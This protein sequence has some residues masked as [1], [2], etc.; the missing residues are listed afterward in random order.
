MSYHENCNEYHNKLIDQY[1]H[2]N[3]NHEQQLL[4]VF[5][6]G[7][8]TLYIN[9]RSYHFILFTLSTV[10]KDSCVRCIIL[11]TCNAFRAISSISTDSTATFDRY[12]ISIPENISKKCFFFINKVRNNLPVLN[13]LPEPVN[14]ITRHVL[15]MFNC[16]KHVFNSLKKK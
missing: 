1:Q 12:L 9:E 5:H 4:L 6:T 8:Q 14:T 13:A 10:L 15:S 7:D 2:Q 11:R 3:N 16:S